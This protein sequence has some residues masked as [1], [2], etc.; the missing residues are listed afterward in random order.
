MTRRGHGEGTI[1][2]RADGRWVGAVSLQDGKRKWF[3]AKTRRDVQEKLIA[4]LRDKHQGLPLAL[5]PRQTLGQFLAHWLQAVAQPKLRPRTL[6][7]YREL[8]MIHI[9]PTLGKRPLQKIAPQDLQHLYAAKLRDNLSPRT[10]GHIHRLLHHALQHAVRWNLVARNVCDLVDPPRV[11]KQ[12]I[13]VL[14][15]E[16]A[17]MLLAAAQGNPLEALYVLALTTGMRQG[18]LFGLKWQDLDLAAATVQ[19]RRSLA[20]LKGR[21]FVELEPKTARSR[22]SILL[23]PL[24][25]SALRRHRSRQLEARL[26]ASSDW[27]DLDLVFCNALGRPL[28]PTNVARRS[29][30][31]LLERAGLP[32]IRFHDLRHSAATLLLS[33]GTHPKIVQEMLGHSQIALTMDTYSHAMPTMQ[34]DAVAR[35][36]E[37]LAG[38]T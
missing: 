9:I 14:S 20:R 10:V 16:H 19:V 11:A 35:L 7:R 38:T 13:Q 5:G 12:E 34:A 30:R 18:E 31:P 8:I 2:K 28:E 25:V 22:R 33:L 24:A 32:R 27:E 3:Y 29:F 36:G 23:T 6:A 15:S 17:K 1:A 37:L 4:A 21:G 26:Q